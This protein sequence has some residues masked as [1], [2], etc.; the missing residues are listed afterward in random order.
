MVP[1]NLPVCLASRL[2]HSVPSRGGWHAL[3]SLH[4][5]TWAQVT[6]QHCQETAVLRSRGPPSSSLVR[7]GK[8]V[9]AQRAQQALVECPAQPVQR[10]QRGPSRGA[11][12]RKT[13]CPRVQ[14]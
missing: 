2:P 5:P 9:S 3:P 8:Q 4:L 6:G 7:S 13:G 11:G 1:A 10:T 12:T 14:G